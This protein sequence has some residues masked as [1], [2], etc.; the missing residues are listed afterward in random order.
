[1]PR[2]LSW[3]ADA[4]YH[5]DV[6]AEG[7]GELTVSDVVCLDTDYNE[8]T[9]VS[10]GVE[11]AGGIVFQND[12]GS[13]QSK[14]LFFEVGENLPS[15]EG[16]TVKC[17]PFA[18][19]SPVDI[20]TGEDPWALTGISCGTAG[21]PWDIGGG[22]GSWEGTPGESNFTVEAYRLKRSYLTVI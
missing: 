16:G 1:M 18:S 2:A 3:V 19:S 11:F 20:E 9:E 4:T 12:T 17:G 10:A 6:E 8:I 7:G 21:G 22:C 5:I 13:V 14:Y 15:W